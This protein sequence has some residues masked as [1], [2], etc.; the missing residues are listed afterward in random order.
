M[1][2]SIGHLIVFISILFTFPGMAQN[3]DYDAVYQKLSKSYTLNP[4]GSI[5]YRLSKSQKLQTYLS[6]NRLFGETFIVFNP[7]FQTLKIDEA[8][9]LMADGKKVITPENAFNKVLPRFARKAPAFNHL[10]E[11]VVTHT[12][13]EIGSII[14]LEYTIQ[15]LNGFFPALMATEVLAET[16]P[17]DRLTIYVKIPQGQELYYHLFNSTLKP[18]IGNANG[19]T[20]YKWEIEHIPAISSEKNQLDNHGNY[21]T[22]IFSTLDSYRDLV[23]YFNNQQAFSNQ[24]STLINE[25]INKLNLKKTDK[26]ELIFALQDEVVKNMKLF[27]VPEEYSGYRLRTPEEVWKSNGG[28]MAEK[29]VLLAS[30]LKQAGISAAPVLV[31]DGNTWDKNVGNL[32]ILEEWIVQTK[33]PEKEPIYLSV[34]QINAFDMTTLLAGQVFMVLN[35]DGSYTIEEPQAEKSSAMMKGIFAIEP[36]HSLS[37]NITGELTGRLNPYLALLRENEKIRHYFSGFSSS[38]IQQSNLLELSSQKVSFSCQV[39]KENMMKKDSSFYFFSIPL[40]KTGM[41]SSGIQTL[42]TKRITPFKLSTPIEENYEFTFAIPE[43]LTLITNDIDIHI[44]NQIGSFVYQVKQKKN[45]VLVRKSLDIKEATIA[46][47]DYSD[48]KSLLDN[49]NINITRELIFWIPQ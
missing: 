28:T 11:M 39:K 20:S 10:R 37:G 23:V 21:P 7:D 42:E 45:T 8:Y 15:T 36:D 30:M 17:V 43:D 3:E 48:F 22:L 18:Q 2:K 16:Q 19:Y 49:W 9:T 14:N 24:E 32:T 44:N 1:K 41:E 25:Y 4:D 13:L 26:S 35:P 5:D 6:I 34:K 12:G 38:N 33:I 29:A 47:E 31:F 46:P 40:L 27:P